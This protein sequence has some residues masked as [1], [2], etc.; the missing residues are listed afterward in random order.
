[1]IKKLI[2]LSK[3]FCYFFCYNNQTVKKTVESFNLIFVNLMLYVFVKSDFF[4]NSR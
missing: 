2:G 4:K 3:M 1:M